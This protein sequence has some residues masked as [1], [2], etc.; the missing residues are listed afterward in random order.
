MLRPTQRTAFV[1]TV[2]LQ[3]HA[4]YRWGAKGERDAVTRQ[5]LFDCSGLVTWALREVVGPD[6]RA[7]HN[8]DKLWAECARVGPG[9]E[10]KPGDLALY[11]SKD[12]PADPEHVMVYLG[13]GLVVGAAG[14]GRRTLTL[15][16]AKLADARVKVFQTLHYR[17]GFMGFV[18]LPLT[19]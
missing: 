16:D 5:R 4:P 14:G 17:P 3:M 15:E 18:R 1:A 10:P 2:L 6:W 11:H 8:T 9:E 19:G 13:D 12:N 7:T